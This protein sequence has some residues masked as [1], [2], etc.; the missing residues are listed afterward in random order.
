PVSFLTAEYLR[1]K[2]PFKNTYAEVL[3]I[4][5]NILPDLEL[6]EHL[7]AL[8]S[9]EV[10][11]GKEGFIAIK[12]PYIFVKG[13]VPSQLKD[14]KPIYYLSTINCIQYPEDIFLNNGEEIKK[15]FEL[16]TKGRVSNT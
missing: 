11:V 5:G 9:G 10:L 8:K 7:V 13:F 6:V 14:F 1:E 12:A 2:F 3:L 16:V 15:D 4:R